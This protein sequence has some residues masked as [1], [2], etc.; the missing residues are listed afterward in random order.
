MA[1]IHCQYC[2]ERLVKVGPDHWQDAERRWNICRTASS[3]HSLHH[4]AEPNDEREIR[5]RRAKDERW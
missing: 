5:E 2:G 4:P 3:P 1:D